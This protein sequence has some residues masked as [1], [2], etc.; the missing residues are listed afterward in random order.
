MVGYN[1]LT[2]DTASKPQ[3][4]LAAGQ[5]MG[6]RDKEKA[7]NR[8]SQRPWGPN[9]RDSSCG[10]RQTEKSPPALDKQ[11]QRDSLRS[12]QFYYTYTDLH[13]PPTN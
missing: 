3:C 10:D 12:L 5:R 8:Y 1:S 13:T 7:H 6:Q 9:M 4:L 2:T 11:R